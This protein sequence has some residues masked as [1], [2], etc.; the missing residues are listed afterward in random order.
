[1]KIFLLNL[2][3]W[4][5]PLLCIASSVWLMLRFKKTR[6]HLGKKAIKWLMWA[7]PAVFGILLIMVFT[8]Y[9]NVSDMFSTTSMG[10][11]LWMF[12]SI[13]IV[14]VIYAAL[15]VLRLKSWKYFHTMLISSLAIWILYVLVA[16]LLTDISGF[17][18]WMSYVVA[19]LYFSCVILLPTLTAAYVKDLSEDPIIVYPEDDAKTPSEMPKLEA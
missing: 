16:I 4:L 19:P 13:V 7:T 6:P 11:L 10:F 18:A 1:M 5:L 3:I 8:M 2:L 15:Y 14:A 17:K 9:A 12:L